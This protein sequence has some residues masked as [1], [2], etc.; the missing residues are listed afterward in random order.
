MKKMEITRTTTKED[1]ENIDFECKKCN[2]CCS[3]DSGI[4]L[5]KDIDRI[6][7]S[8]DMSPEEFSKKYL[9]EKD[10][11]D[12]KVHK[13]KLNKKNKPFGPCI[14]LQKEGCKIHDIK[15]LH[16]RLGSGCS[17]YGQDINI[18][19]ML[20]YIVDQDNPEAIRQWAIYLK[21]HPTIKLGELK[22]LVPDEDKL[23]KI[24]LFKILKTGDK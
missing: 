14:F 12:K 22:D 5:D 15:P 11:F 2:H 10:L 7:S 8:F 3:Y 9:V 13:A 18:W 20:N 16:C 1:I 6:S 21:T 4:F 24:L 17:E 23:N 19:F